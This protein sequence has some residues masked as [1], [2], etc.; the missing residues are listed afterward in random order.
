[1]PK[2]IIIYETRKG[3]TQ[4]MAETIQETLIE[5][6][7]KTTAK[8]VSEIELDELKDCTGV[9]LGSATY[10]K[11]MIGSMKTFLFRLEKVDLKGKVGASFGAYGWSGEAVG[12]LSETMKHIYGMEIIEPPVKLPGSAAGAD[13][14]LYQNFA[15]N[16]ADKI[17]AHK[18]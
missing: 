10:N 7:V 11:D 1:M 3:S 16:I 12:M 17:K 4:T 9:I 15:R 18:K 5:C 6:G 8:R 13:K 2:A 14:S